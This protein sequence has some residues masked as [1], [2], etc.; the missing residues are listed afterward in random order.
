MRTHLD[1][2]S[3]TLSA[4][5]LLGSRLFNQSTV[6]V[7]YYMFQAYSMVACTFKGYIPFTVTIR[8]WLIPCAVQYILL[9]YLFYT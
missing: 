4:G 6:D 9:D 5:Y 2:V 1:Y 8:Y 7:W 3:L